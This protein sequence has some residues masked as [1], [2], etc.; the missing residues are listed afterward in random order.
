MDILACISMNIWS[1]WLCPQINPSVFLCTAL[2]VLEDKTYLVLCFYVLKLCLVTAW[3]ACRELVLDRAF[4]KSVGWPGGRCF[5]TH[6]RKFLSRTYINTHKTELVDC[7]G[8]NYVNLF[9]DVVG[10]QYISLPLFSRQKSLRVVGGIED[11]D[12]IF[13]MIKESKVFNGITLP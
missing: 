12:Q 10:L 7:T 5:W 9:F 1:F 13:V 11:S 6:Q 8:R 3:V 2:H 4:A